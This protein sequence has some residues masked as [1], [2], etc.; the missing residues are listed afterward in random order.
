MFRIVKT[1]PL[2]YF[3]DERIV[4]N[5]YAELG[6][7]F[8]DFPKDT[9]VML[10]ISERMKEDGFTGNAIK[11]IECDVKSVGHDYVDVSRFNRDEPIMRPV[12]PV[13]RATRF[14][15]FCKGI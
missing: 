15:Q 8:I 5:M 6:E 14:I 4:R 9:P 11:I 13:S 1:A 10:T 7:L 3:E 12:E 2:R